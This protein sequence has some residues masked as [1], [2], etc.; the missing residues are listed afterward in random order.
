MLSSLKIVPM[1]VIHGYYQVMGFMSE[2]FTWDLTMSTYFLQSHWIG[3]SYYKRGPEGNE[4]HKTNVPHIRVEFRN[5]VIISNLV[6]YVDYL[7]SLVFLTCVH[8]PMKLQIWKEEMQLVY[9]GK[10]IIPDEIDK[11]I[12]LLVVSLI[13]GKLIMLAEIF[14]H[15]PFFGCW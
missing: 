7:S 14:L 10:A 15:M 4:I 8:C 5:M 1:L 12:L 11:W 13:P 2:N 3:K 9:L 6:F